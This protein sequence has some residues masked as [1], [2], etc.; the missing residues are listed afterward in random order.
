[1]TNRNSPHYLLIGSGRLATHLHHYFLE[2]GIVC[3]SWCRARDPQMKELKDLVNWA[4]VVMLLIS[5]R[6][7]DDFYTEHLSSF[8]AKKI[9]HCS[10]SHRHPKMLGFHPLM[11]FSSGTL[12]PLDTY[13]SM[14]FVGDTPSQT[15]RQWFSQLDNPYFQIGAEDRAYYHCLCVLS[16]NLSTWLWQEVVKRMEGQLNIPRW[17]LWPYMDRLAAN[18][19]EDLEKALTGP[20]VRGDQITIVEN[21]AALIEK[22]DL[23]LEDLYQSFVRGVQKPRVGANHEDENSF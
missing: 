15:F 21:R 23:S 6:S 2:E 8:P 16:G 14:A 20:V 13:R 5:D 12:Y 18:L 9:V 19:K 3:K 22:G 10:G 11:S 4:D 17:A 1:M 7:L